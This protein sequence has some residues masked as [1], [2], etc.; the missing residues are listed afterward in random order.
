MKTLIDN[1][2]KTDLLNAEPIA[3]SIQMLLDERVG[4]PITIGVHG[5]WGAGKS[6]ILLMLS[7]G[8]SKRDDVLSI[9]FNAWRYQGFE[10]AKLALIEDIVAQLIE[11]RSLAT[12]AAGAIKDLY[13]RINLLK[14]AKHAGG[15]AFTLFTGIPAPGHLDALL[16]AVKGAITNPAGLMEKEALEQASKVLEGSLK[17]AQAKH[18]PQEIQEF[19][20]AFSTLLDQAGVKQLVIL[21][22]DLDRCLPEVAIQ[23]LEALRLFLFMPKTAIVVAADE[24]MIEYAVRKHFPEVPEATLSQ[25]FARNYLEKLIQVPFRLPSLGVAETRIYVALLLVEAELGSSDPSFLALLKKAREVLRKPW[26]TNGFNAQMIREA[27]PDASQQIHTATTLS[28]Q[29]GPI[30]AQGSRGNPRQI[31]RFLNMLILRMR[32]AEAR[33]IADEIQ[34]PVLAKLM[35][36]ERFNTRPFEAIAKV[37]GQA[38]DGRCA[39]LAAAEAV[40]DNGAGGSADALLDSAK[41]VLRDWREE[42]SFIAWMRIAPKLGELDLRPYLFVSR[43]QK[44]ST[45]MVSAAGALP[46]LALQLMGGKM[47]VASLE[48][49][50]R[51]LT[52]AEAQTVFDLVRTD[53]LSESDMT[54]TPKGAFGLRLLARVYPVLQAQLL[55]TLEGLDAGKIGAWVVTGWSDVFTEPVA[56][57]RHKNMIE[58]WGEQTS[59]STLAA[60]AK[61]AQKVT[62]PGRGAH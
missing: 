47:A 31:K 39:A 8:A 55:D 41:D 54:T 2:T 30:L 58:A 53:M 44:A 18:V 20:K 22:D 50:V 56:K 38:P 15:L 29:I 60:A 24:P 62:K 12:K 23:T 26:L 5:D 28:E 52:R 16:T 37:A 49:S 59:N 45:F 13:E 40:I 17:P 27:I 1:E 46:D 36:L 7:D 4:D 25:G 3:R 57:K 21:V 35:L 32:A 51:K 34:A 11:E 14:L 42:E 19:R 48:A 9:H 33:G 61:T 6:S 10:D 43:D